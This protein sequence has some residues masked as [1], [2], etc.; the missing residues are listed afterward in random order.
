[1]IS[2]II[3]ENIKIYAYHGVLPE[4]TI[5]GTYYLINA[6]IHADLWKATE[7]DDLND[8]IN[9]ALVNEIIHQEMKIPSQLL[10]HVIG[11]IMKRIAAEFKQVNFIKIK[12]TKVQPPMPGEMTGVSLEMEKAF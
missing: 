5:L 10:E 1:M 8:T 3:L 6:E 2:K 7:S 12:L 9:Y 11:R 4:E